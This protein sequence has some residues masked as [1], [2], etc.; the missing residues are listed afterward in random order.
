MKKDIIKPDE[1]ASESKIRRGDCGVHLDLSPWLSTQM[2]SETIKG[3]AWY[4][5]TIRGSIYWS[6]PLLK[7]YLSYGVNS[8]EYKRAVESRIANLPKVG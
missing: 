4:Q 2:R 8:D 3:I 5:P 1:I 6:I 7:I